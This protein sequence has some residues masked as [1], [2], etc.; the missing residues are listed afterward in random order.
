MNGGKD[1]FTGAELGL[2]I[3]KIPQSYGEF[4]AEFLRQLRVIADGTKKY[5]GAM[6][7]KYPRMHA[8][9][10]YTSTFDECILRG[11][12]IFSAFGAKYNNTSI[13][14]IGLATAADSLLAVKKLVYDDKILSYEE[15]SE[16]MR[17]NW[18]GR[19][20]LRLAVKNKYP[21]YGMGDDRSDEVAR[22]I[23]RRL[24]EM[25]NG[26]PNEKGGVY[27]LGLHSITVRWTMG[28]ALGATPDGRLRGEST[29]LN[30]G[31][32]FGADRNGAVGHIRSVASLD[33]S[34]SPNSVTLDLDLHA[35]AVS[36]ENGLFAMYASLMTY[37][38]LGGFSVHYNVLDSGILKDAQKNP[39]AY[40]NLQVRLC[41]WNAL[42]NRLSRAEQ[43]EYISR[44]DGGSLA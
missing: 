24:A 21:K 14:A 8:S 41:G 31:A 15:L 40:K 30:S 4:Y 18:Q 3:E 26:V 6:E 28:K 9:P 10:F 29:S 34:L 17:N 38:K 39:D 20:D 43:D 42:F 2:P 19:E 1:V 12:D 16:L 44:F 35:S 23:V 22:D 11:V 32:S 33:A 36:G 27:R 5:I 7:R 13:T 25:I 37:I